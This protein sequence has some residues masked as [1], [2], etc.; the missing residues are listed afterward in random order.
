ML[1]AEMKNKISIQRV[2]IIMQAIMFGVIFILTTMLVQEKSYW[3]GY[4][5]AYNTGQADGWQGCIE[6]NNL[7]GRY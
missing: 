1:R 6:E 7:Y 4:N 3:Q 2:M 5:D